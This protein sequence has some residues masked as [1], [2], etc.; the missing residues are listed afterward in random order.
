MRVSLSGV[1]KNSAATILSLLDLVKE[2][3]SDS[4]LES[5]ECD[6]EPQSYAGL[7]REIS[8]HATETSKGE[9]TLEEFATHYCL[10]D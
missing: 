3:Y 6:L 10:K 2:R 7:L 5:I 9:H 4:E 1:C 8:K